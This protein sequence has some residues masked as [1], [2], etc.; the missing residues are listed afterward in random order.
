MGKNISQIVLDTN[1][2][3]N[4]EKGN[5]SIIN[6]VDLDSNLYITSISVFEFAMGDSFEENKNHLDTYN[7]LSFNK[8]DGLL[9][10]KILKELI[11]QGQEIEFRDTM[12]SAI[13]INNNIPLKTL[14]IKH[15]ERL[16][17]FGL[18]LD[19]F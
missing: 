15:F 4:L 7:I 10:A 6:S 3:I 5:N 8:E 16:K 18:Q 17:Q 14:N 1:V 12:I 9:A 13:C 11:K 19:K 2:L